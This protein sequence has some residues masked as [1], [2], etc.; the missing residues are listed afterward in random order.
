MNKFQAWFLT[1]VVA[2]WSSF[3]HLFIFNKLINF[4]RGSSLV[5]WFPGA[6][7]DLRLPSHPVS[8]SS[9]LSAAG[10]SIRTRFHMYPIHCFQRNYSIFI[11]MRFHTYPSIYCLQTSAFKSTVQTFDFKV[12]LSNEL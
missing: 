8:L 2:P 6:A 7:P 5:W 11:R 10:I 1:Y 3:I 12:I 9:V 4:R